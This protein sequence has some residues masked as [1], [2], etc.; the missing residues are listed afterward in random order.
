MNVFDSA[1]PRLVPPGH[2]IFEIAEE[3]TR[4]QSSFNSRDFFSVHLILRDGKGE[5]FDMVKNFNA[6]MDSFHLFLRA[7]G[8][9]TQANGITVPPNVPSY[10]GRKFKGNI[11][12][13][14]AK[15]DQNKMVQDII[16]ITPYKEETQAQVNNLSGIT[17]EE[18][19]I[20]Y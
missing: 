5:H 1:K 17:N 6:E 12:H 13:R 2:Y 19:E 18:D 20:L 7:M 3:P 4:K 10:R 16:N 9:Q 14:P 11:I 15:N 8:G